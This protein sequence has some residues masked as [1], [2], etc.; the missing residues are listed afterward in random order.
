MHFEDLA[1]RRLPVVWGRLA[2]AEPTE[3]ECE[4]KSE[5]VMR[6]K[7]R[8]DVGGQF[9]AFFC[10]RNQS[11]QFLENSRHHGIDAVIFAMNE[12]EFLRKNARQTNVRWLSFSIMPKT[13]V[14]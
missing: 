3:H 9:S 1:Q 10:A 13:W 4:I 14:S 11:V 2:A 8:V 5:Q 7:R 6:E 12:R